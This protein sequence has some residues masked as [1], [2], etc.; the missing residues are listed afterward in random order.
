[1]AVEYPPVAAQWY[2]PSQTREDTQSLD[3]ESPVSSPTVEPVAVA[4]SVSTPPPPLRSEEHSSPT[5]TPV[6]S[7]VD[8]C[9]IPVP[10]DVVTPVPV[11]VVVPVSLAPSPDK[12]GPTI[13]PPKPYWARR[14]LPALAEPPPLRV[15]PKIKTRPDKES[16]TVM[17]SINA[18]Y[19][20]ANTTDST[21]RLV[22]KGLSSLKLPVFMVHRK[23]YNIFEYIFLGG[24]KGQIK[25]KDFEMVRSAFHF[26]SVGSVP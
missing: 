8:I 2:M 18:S 6:E 16:A 21:L 12:P 23:V 15:G 3:P 11:E 10:V 22:E 1:M 25:F 5:L 26:C 7:P 13:A 14:E 24:E 19:P 17:G 20:V 9:I 4:P